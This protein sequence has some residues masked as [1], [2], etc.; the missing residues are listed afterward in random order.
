MDVS[1]TFTPSNSNI[2]CLHIFYLSLVTILSN[3]HPLL[4]SIIYVKQGQTIPG[5]IGG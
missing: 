3:H 1:V 2:Y 4:E 5:T